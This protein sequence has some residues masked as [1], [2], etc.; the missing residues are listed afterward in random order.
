MFQ[1]YINCLKRE[2]KCKMIRLRRSSKHAYREERLILDYNI[3][4]HLLYRG[5]EIAYI[6]ECTIMRKVLNKIMSNL[7]PL[8][9]GKIGDELILPYI[10]PCVDKVVKQS[11]SMLMHNSKLVMCYILD[12]DEKDKHK[13]KLNIYLDYCP[14][15]DDDLISK[16]R[17]LNSI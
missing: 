17:I 7:C 14:E 16:C 8:L 15:G 4:E 5:E 13:K 11:T 3:Q 10:Y 2:R 9:C 1:N 6:Y 12:V